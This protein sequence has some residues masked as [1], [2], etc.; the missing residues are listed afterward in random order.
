MPE[1]SL[2]SYI[3]RIKHESAFRTLGKTGA[4]SNIG[5][6]FL[7]KTAPFSDYTKKFF[8]RY[9]ILLVLKGH[10][11]YCDSTGNK[12]R[13]SPGSVAQRMPDR[14]HTTSC[15]TPEDWAECFI[16]FSGDTMNTLETHGIINKN[17]PV[18]NIK[19]TLDLIRKFEVLK[20]L[21]KKCKEN[22]LPE[23]FIN[24]QQIVHELFKLD[25]NHPENLHDRHDVIIKN[26]CIELGKH[27][28][29]ELSLERIA[30]ENNISYERFRKV[31][32]EKTG[33][34]P[35]QFRL[36]KKIEQAQKL[37]MTESCPAKNIALELGYPDEYCFAKQFKKYTGMTP[38]EFRKITS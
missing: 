36:N 3:S 5:C 14:G 34:S 21:L 38:G 4:Q 15:D 18:F 32:K 9:G 25:Q 7:K 27:L 29:S 28:S 33:V 31:F 26:A 12:F 20:N 16:V 35:W 24:A 11:E 22:E 1:H 2:N 6:G 23:L 17:I 30:S 37:L 8:S 10:G 13:L 19:L